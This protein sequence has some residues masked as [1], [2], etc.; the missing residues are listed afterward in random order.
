MIEFSD[1]NA[2]RSMFLKKEKK[3]GKKKKLDLQLMWSGRVYIY[4][5]AHVLNNFL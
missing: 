5:T 2:L 4:E 1:A 3:K